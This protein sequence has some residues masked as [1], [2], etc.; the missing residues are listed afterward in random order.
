MADL[1]P[2]LD[3][4]KLSLQALL[5]LA[6]ELEQAV[7][8]E[9]GGSGDREWPQRRSEGRHPGGGEVGLTLET[10]QGLEVQGTLV[11]HS[12]SGFRTAHDSAALWVGREVE[13]EHTFAKGRARVIWNRVAGN[14]IHT[15][16][17]VIKESFPLIEGRRG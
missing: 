6:S 1:N 5:V 17:L 16:F 10:A 13:F 3:L 9:H 15:G 12:P 4:D 7:A 14:G 11:D 8:L 2:P